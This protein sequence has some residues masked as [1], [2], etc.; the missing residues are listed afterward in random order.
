MLRCLLAGGG[1]FHNS[2]L[3]KD[4]E[5]IFCCMAPD[6]C[7]CFFDLAGAFHYK[8]EH[9]VMYGWSLPLVM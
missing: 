8:Q 5:V 1:L 3:E 9:T 6:P 4:S 7:Q 2:V